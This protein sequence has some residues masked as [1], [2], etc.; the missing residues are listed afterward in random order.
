VLVCFSGRHAPALTPAALALLRPLRSRTRTPG[1]LRFCFCLLLSPPSLL[2][3]PPMFYFSRGRLCH[4]G[5]FRAHSRRRPVLFVSSGTCWHLQARP[6]SPRFPSV[7][8]QDVACVSCSPPRFSLH[9][10]LHL[11]FSFIRPR[12][13]LLFC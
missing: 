11:L 12:S 6:R 9:P 7:N 2:C 10:R 5:S 1:E 3:S 13:S 8:L 4:A